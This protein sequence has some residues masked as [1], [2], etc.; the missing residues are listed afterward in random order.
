MVALSPTTSLIKGQ[1][2]YEKF[3]RDLK[4]LVGYFHVSHVEDLNAFGEGLNNGKK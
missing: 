4:D 1:G 3:L 2:R